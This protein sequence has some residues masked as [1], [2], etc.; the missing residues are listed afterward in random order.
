VAVRTVTLGA[1]IGNRWIVEKG[2][3]ANDRV[4][5]DGPSLKDGTLVSPHPAAS[6]AEAP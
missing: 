1:R 6:S 2:L 4:V 5:V 3:Q